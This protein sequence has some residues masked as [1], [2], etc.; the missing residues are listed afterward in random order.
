MATQAGGVLMETFTWC[1]QNEMEEEPTFNV[2]SIQFGDGYKQE[3]GQGI[4]NVSFSYNAEFLGKPADMELIIQ[5]ILRH[6]GYK[7]FK[8]TPPGK[9]E[10][11]FF[12]AK[13]LQVLHESSL[14]KRVSA[15]FEQRF[16]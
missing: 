11:M 14:V 10:E 15:R 6:Q 7:P 8:W 5:F 16:L 12:V 9:T 13:D 4:N 3:F 2:G 1:P